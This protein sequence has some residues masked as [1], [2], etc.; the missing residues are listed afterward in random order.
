MENI[1]KNNITNLKATVIYLLVIYL[2]IYKYKYTILL[3]DI[4]VELY[5]MYKRL[6]KKK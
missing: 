5:L 3:Y 2:F 4:Y 1:D 6:F